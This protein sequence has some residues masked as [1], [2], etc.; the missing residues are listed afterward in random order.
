MQEANRQKIPVALS[1]ASM[2]G[3][4]APL[5]ND[6]IIGNCCRVLKGLDVDGD[7]L[8]LEVIDA[9]GPGGNFMTSPHTMKYMRSEYYGGN[10][11]SDR[12]SRNRWEKDGA[13]DTRQ[14]ALAMAK[15]LIS[16]PRPEPIAK[17]VVSEIRKKFESIR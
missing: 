17:E 8:A 16:N 7:H 6:E 2:A 10:G 12:K 14:R 11:V 4:T 3:A 13:Q 1:S 15:Q 9:V 5:T